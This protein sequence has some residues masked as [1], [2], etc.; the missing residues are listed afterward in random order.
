M[1]GEHPTEPADLLKQYLGRRADL[2]RFFVA[3]TGSTADA[4]DIVQ[5][6]YLKVAQI[7]S[8]MRRPLGGKIGPIVRSGFAA[9]GPGPGPGCE[10]G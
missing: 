7:V 1:Q 2:I 4:E 5:E 8:V 6:L 10:I 3:R 9:V